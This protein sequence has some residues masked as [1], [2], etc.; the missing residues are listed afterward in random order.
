M[1]TAPLSNQN[2]ALGALLRQNFKQVFTQE[3]PPA[4]KLY[5]YPYFD[6]EAIKLTIQNGRKYAEDYNKAQEEK[7]SGINKINYDYRKEIKSNPHTAEQR[8]IFDIYKK[9]HK[10]AKAEP[11]AYNE[12]VLQ[13]NRTHGTHFLLRAYKTL[14]TEIAITFA[15]LVNFYAAQVKANNGRKMEAGVTTAGTLP[16]LL[17]NSENLKRYKVDGVKQSPYQN[18]AILTHVHNLVEAGLL[19]NYKSHGRNMGFSIDFNPEILAIKDTKSSKSQNPEKQSLIKFKKGK[20]P[21]SDSYTR[22]LKDDNEIKGDACASPGERNA[23]LAATPATRNTY[24]NT[25][26]G[27]KPSPTASSEK[28]NFGKISPGEA[29]K[30]EQ[31]KPGRAE[32]DLEAK[33]REKWE[34][35][36]ELSLDMHANHI[37]IDVKTLRREAR[38]GTMSQ[39]MFRTLI[40][41]EFMKYISGLKKGNQSGAG[42]FYRAFQELEENKL[43]NMAGRYFTKDVMVDHFEKWLWMVDHAERWAKKREW[44]LLYINAYLD[45]TKR[46]GKQVGFW[47]LE[48]HWNKNEKKTAKNKTQKLK[49]LEKSQKKI[50]EIKLDRVKEF[51][52]RSVKPGTNSRSLS[53]FE[54]GRKAVRKYLYE[55]ISFE[56]LHRYCRHN[57]SNDIVKGLQNLIESEKQNLTKYN[58]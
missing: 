40:F 9:E 41:Q 6:K 21:Y 5:R 23:A 28:E 36:T 46:D 49:R 51:G 39:Q 52:Y 53:D 31:S 37:P 32:V 29:K 34:L 56:E 54:K 58:A 42:A 33:I 22:T 18:E 24:K 1:N 2:N 8:I 15:H 17:T 12:M 47:Y 26:S 4:K 27:E 43:V 55:K 11:M 10:L 48:K 7:S 44:N 25:R 16:R 50:K 38:N 3:E 35:C 30:Q 13:F 14:R 20:Q 19:I 57:L 45:T